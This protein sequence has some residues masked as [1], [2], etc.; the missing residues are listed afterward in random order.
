[1][2]KSAYPA[3]GRPSEEAPP[4]RKGP[5]P[6]R[7]FMPIWAQGLVFVIPCL[8]IGVAIWAGM[9]DSSFE[10]GALRAEAEV[11]SIRVETTGGQKNARGEYTTTAGR[12]IYPT[13]R[14]TAEDG[15]TYTVETETNRGG[16]AIENEDRIWVAYMPNNPMRARISRGPWETW[17]QPLIIISICATI[18]IGLA[19]LFRRIGRKQRAAY[20]ERWGIDP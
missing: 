9:N 18:V 5:P 17:E 3:P 4:P 8:F 20:R 19:F 13:V 2:R 14:F 15:E 12:A 10:K 16:L 11:L 7:R 6:F 1:M